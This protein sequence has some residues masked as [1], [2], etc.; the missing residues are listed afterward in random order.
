MGTI[1]RRDRAQA[2]RI[3]T[4]NRRDNRSIFVYDLY[5]SVL[6]LMLLNFSNHGIIHARC[7]FLPS[8]SPANLHNLS[9]LRLIVL[10][11]DTRFPNLGT[12]VR[13]SGFCAGFLFDVADTALADMTSF[14]CVASFWIYGRRGYS[15][16]L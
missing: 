5:P 13:L 15:V 6:L 7:R 8:L 16:L 3:R 1:T 10:G 9:L 2:G 11:V 12:V 14:S 4:Y